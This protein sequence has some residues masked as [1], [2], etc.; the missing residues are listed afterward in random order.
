MT[1]QEQRENWKVLGI[2]PRPSGRALCGHQ[3]AFSESCAVRPADP[4]RPHAQRTDRD[5]AAA[6]VQSIAQ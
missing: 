4:E 2:L 3:W 6:S 5:R 1:E